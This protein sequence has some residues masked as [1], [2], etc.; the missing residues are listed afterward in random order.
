MPETQH[1]SEG[2]RR[3]ARNT[4]VIYV[5]MA[6]TIL[7]GL[8]TSRLVLQ[9]LGASDVGIYSAVGS[10]VALVA[11]ITGALSA[12]TVRFMNYEMGRPG[13]DTRRM[14]NICHLI[15]IGGAVLLFLILETLGLW[16]IHN[17]LNV[18]PGKEGDAMFVFQVSTFV[19]CL[20]IANVPFQS[21]FN[22]HER[23]AV[24]AVVDIV[25]ALVKLA[26]V[27]GLLVCWQEGGLRL[28]ALLMSVTTLISFV[29]YHWL[30]RRRW[31][32]MI[33][34]APVREKAA[35]KEVLSFG[36]YNLL[37]SSSIIARSQGSNMLINA[38]FGTSVNAA[39]YYAATIQNYVN[40]FIANF[41]TA[42][43]PQIT[44]NVSG[45]KINQSVLLAERVCRICILLFLLLFFPIWSELDFILR[46]WLGENIPEGTVAMS[47]WTL[48]VAAV[49]ATSAGLAQ[50][51]N[52]IGDV[53]W[54]KI[55]F[56]FLYLSCLP[57]GWLLFQ[58]GYPAWSIIA[59]FVAADLLNR[60]I[61]F[62]LLRVR[63]G[64]DVPHF[65]RQAYWR[66]L[67]S[68]LVL[69]LYLGLYRLLPLS[70]AWAKIG[71]L[72]L[73]FAVTACVLFSV[74]LRKGERVALI[75]GFV[76]KLAAFHPLKLVSDKTFLKVCYQRIFHRPLNLKHPETFNEKLQW[77]KLYD[78]DPR[79]T[80]F[81][82][83]FRAK[84]LVAE[85]I[86]Q[87]HIIPT[88]GVWEHFDDIDFSALPR[89]FVLK[90]T[91]DSGGLV[92][93]RDKDTLDRT[94]TRDKLESSLRS[95]FYDRFREWQY[96][97]IPPRIIAETY[98]QDG[99]NPCL[100]DYKFYCFNGEPAFLYVSEG[101]ENHDSARLGFL[102]LDWTPAPF[103]RSDY[104][105]FETLPPKPARFE[106]MVDIAKRL[107]EGFRFVRVDLYEINGEVYFSEMTFT[108]SSGFVPF[109]P[110]E[111]DREIGS[112][113][114]I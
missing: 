39:Y 114:R 45:G 91:H 12:T 100:K 64:F 20:G 95:N 19:A 9:A 32:E 53:K 72:V 47:R 94:A 58:S 83:K 54:Y 4:A 67:I 79:Y 97:D 71:G 3:I 60:I 76:L 1:I 5:R 66:P 98:M 23:F 107:A 29:A 16:Y 44:Q 77:M 78:R 99:E 7:V 109:M 75:S 49:S 101:L 43:A 10:T 59:C 33:R 80:A 14:F 108:P 61:Q 11:F 87:E 6:V 96:K 111:A 56:A 82:D 81:S 85:R 41:D 73:T 13:G 50:L 90:C 92:I 68:S 105:E 103:R 57:A 28:Y 106:E 74:G 63:S 36:S 104:A 84:E 48:L 65:L 26:L 21:L 22:V 27:V 93:C 70:S 25:N 38:F 52:A 88:L 17:G 55:T 31:P 113:L 15:H 40:Q 62:V 86:G 37:S 51:I 42:A 30:C 8:I 110:E 24:I 69:V 18:P 46:L 35:Y 89:Q 102:N 2:N 34:W 112:L